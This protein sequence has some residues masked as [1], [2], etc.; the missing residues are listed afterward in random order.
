MRAT[1]STIKINNQE[2]NDFFLN[3][4][5]ILLEFFL[6]RYSQLEGSLLRF[7]DR[8]GTNFPTGQF[9]ARITNARFFTKSYR[10]VNTAP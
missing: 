1:T 6:R 7:Y 8:R 9:T 2:K 10:Y 4:I 3:N 5:P